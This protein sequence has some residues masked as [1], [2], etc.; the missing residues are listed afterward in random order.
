MMVELTVI[1]LI[2]AGIGILTPVA[3]FM[4]WIINMMI[5]KKLATFKDDLV[6]ALDGKYY[7]RELLDAKFQIISLKI[8]VSLGGDGGRD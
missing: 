4:S 1:E 3:G 2:G 8:G 7:T 5:S 6:T